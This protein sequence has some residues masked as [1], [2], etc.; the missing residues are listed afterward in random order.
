M[1]KP[2]C[3]QDNMHTKRQAI[4]SG[5]VMQKR[6]LPRRRENSVEKTAFAINFINDPNYE[7]SARSDG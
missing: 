3:T 5:D 6:R 1:H 2:T 7:S 4:E